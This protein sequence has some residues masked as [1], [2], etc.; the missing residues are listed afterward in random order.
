[1][2]VERGRIGLVLALGIVGVAAALALRAGR[3]PDPASPSLALSDQVAGRITGEGVDPELVYLVDLPGYELAEQSAGVVG[4]DGFG[5]TYVSTDG[6]GS[7]VLL[8]VDRGR[9]SDGDDTCAA[10]A[11]CT[12][13]DTG[14]YRVEADLHEYLV[15]RD[16]GALL[17]LTAPLAGV[18]RSDLGAAAAGARR[19]DLD[20]PASGSDPGSGPSPT[21]VPR[22]DLPS[23]GDGAP[24]NTV[25]PGG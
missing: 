12:S 13:D 17:R 25:G 9:I 18:D 16:G 6:T 7:Q 8:L 22:G 14:L 19:I 21:T 4:N 3:D 10:A 23:S 24:N 15:E 11:T 5:A 2:R 20:L 1:V